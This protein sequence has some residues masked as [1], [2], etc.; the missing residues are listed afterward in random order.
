LGH[1]WLRCASVSG[2]TTMSA[3]TASTLDRGGVGP[4]I[5]APPCRSRTHMMSIQCAFTNSVR[6]LAFARIQAWLIMLLGSGWATLLTPDP[7]VCGWLTVV[8]A[9]CSLA[10]SSST[11]RLAFVLAAGLSVLWL[12]LF[13]GW[14]RPL[15][16]VRVVTFGISER[17]S[18]PRRTVPTV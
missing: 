7:D 10:A 17:A 14:A 8:S 6:W 16:S 18:S 11:L 2:V 15:V 12:F 1:A 5:P 9:G 13:A 4:G 3:G